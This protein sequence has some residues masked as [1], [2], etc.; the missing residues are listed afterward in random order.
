MMGKTVTRLGGI[1]ATCPRPPV[2]GK[3]PPKLTAEHRAVRVQNKNKKSLRKGGRKNHR[4]RRPGAYSKAARVASPSAVR[5]G[6]R[7]APANRSPGS[8]LCV[9]TPLRRVPA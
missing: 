3:R 7:A 9:V 6:A 4:H 1:D 8:R 2:M 5:G